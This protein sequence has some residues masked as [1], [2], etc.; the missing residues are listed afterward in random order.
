MES[1]AVPIV[2]KTGI[3]VPVYKGG[4]KDPLEV[5]SFRGVT[6]TSTLTKV[7]EFLIVDR[8]QLFLL[9]PGL[10]RQP[11]SIQEGDLFHRGDLCNTG[12]NSMVKKSQ[13]TLKMFSFT[14]H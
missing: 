1:E 12:N 11:V 10:P 5:D 13:V 6:S 2:L 3:L 7:L 4:G 9:E 8:L 14:N